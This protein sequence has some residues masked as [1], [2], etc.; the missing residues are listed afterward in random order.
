M[1]LEDLLLPVNHPLLSLPNVV[2]LL[3]IGSASVKTR[4][5]MAHLA[6]DNMINVFKGNK[7]ITPIVIKK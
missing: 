2:A 4:M 5:K 6:V 3:H 1:N 7:P